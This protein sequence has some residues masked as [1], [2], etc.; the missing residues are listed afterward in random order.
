[1]PT[2]PL[3]CRGEA[4]AEFCHGIRAEAMRAT[5]RVTAANLVGGGGADAAAEGAPPPLFVS[6]DDFVPT[7]A[8][9]LLLARDAA[10]AGEGAAAGP[11]AAPAAAAPTFGDVLLDSDGGGGRQG[12]GAAAA[13]VSVTCGGDK[14]VSLTVRRVV[15]VLE[16][17]EVLETQSFREEL[18]R[19]R[20]VFLAG[21]SDDGDGVRGTMDE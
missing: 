10:A 7:A 18:A 14:R 6:P 12:G 9:L 20:A 19:R 4:Y 15:N 1:M 11:A 3:G 16:G 21:A 13:A 8:A 2:A 17:R 5:V